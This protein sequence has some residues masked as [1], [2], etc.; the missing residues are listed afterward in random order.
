MIIVNEVKRLKNEIKALW[1]SHNKPDVAK[2]E[3]L[4]FEML[5][6]Y[7][8]I[9]QQQAWP[10]RWENVDALYTF[11]DRISAWVVDDLVMAIWAS[12][13]QGLPNS[14][15]NWD[16]SEKEAGMALMLSRGP[17]CLREMTDLEG[18]NVYSAV[19]VFV[20]PRQELLTIKEGAGCLVVLVEQAKQSDSS[21]ESEVTILCELPKHR[22]GRF[23]PSA[24]NDAYLVLPYTT[25]KGK[26]KKLRLDFSMCYNR[27]PVVRRLHRWQRKLGDLA[28]LPPVFSSDPTLPILL[29]VG[30]IGELWLN[31]VFTMPVAAGGSG[32]GKGRPPISRLTC[33]RQEVIA[34]K[35]LADWMDQDRVVY[36]IPPAPKD[37]T[38]DEPDEPNDPVDD[39]QC[40]HGGK[41]DENATSKKEEDESEDDSDDESKV[42]KDQTAVSRD[43]SLGAS[44]S[45]HGVDASA[46]AGNSGIDLNMGPPLPGLPMPTW[47]LSMD[48]LEQLGDDLY[49]YSGELFWGLEKTSLAMLDRILSG[50][51]RSGSRAREYIYE[52]AA[53]A[54]NFFSRA[55]DMEAKL[56]SSEALKFREVVNGMKESIH[57]LIR[58]TASAE[59]SYENAAAN[60]DNILASVSD[61]VKEFEDSHGEEQ[62]QAYIFRSME[63][64]RGVH[65]SLDGTQFIPLVVSNTT[66]HHAL[67]M[68][69]RVNQSQVPLQIMMLPMRTQ[70]GTMGTGLKFIEYLSKRVLALDVKLGPTTTVS[71]ESGGEGP[72]VQSSTGTGG[73][74]TPKVASTPAS[75]GGPGSS[76]T[77]LSTP[78]PPTAAH[79]HGA[80]RAKTPDM[81]SK[82]KAMFSP[83]ASAA[84]AKFKGMSDDDRSSRKRRGESS[85]REVVSKKTKVDDSKKTKVDDFKKTK[86]DDFKKTNVD[87]LKKPKVDGFKIAIDDDD[88]DSYLSPTP[89]KS[90]PP[91][92][93]VKKK[94][95]KKKVPS[96]DES[97]SSSDDERPAPKKSKIDRA[98]AVAWMN[99][100]RANKWKRDL[101]H[102]N[103]YR[104]QK[105]LY[106][107]DLTGGPNS[108]HHVDLLTQLLGARQLGLN[109]THIDTRLDELAEESSSSKSARRLLKALKEVHAETMGRS[110]VYP[111]YVVK[112][113]LEP[114]SQCVIQKGDSNHWD[115]SAMIG[116]YNLH[117]YEAVGKGNK[118]VDSKMVTKGYCSFC[119]YNAGN[120]GSINNHI[121]V[122]YR[123]VLEC[124]FTNC[125]VIMYDAERMVAH[126]KDKHKLETD[127]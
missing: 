126:S 34:G 26:P 86:V 99:L 80:S 45:G 109:I 93:E 64:I 2:E 85:S 17:S 54:L 97:S 94:K 39:D 67:A 118:K 23:Y 8:H 38:A 21:S 90:E 89:H 24:V 32:L 31:E 88:S 77:P 102:V 46:E 3:L 58:R 84:L 22:H 127:A 116:L 60:F 49:A 124:G 120:N 1:K 105:G 68:S 82:P 5:D 106:A 44:Y 37:D 69:H 81:P 11:T 83:K 100:D 107:K 20:H 115:T 18:E 7:R 43:S 51:K 123:L 108:T 15:A 95:T 112:A 96:S 12:G 76:K 87:D 122:H 59:E 48:V 72:G 33:C 19:V 4:T 113:F 66:I 91:K 98:E 16:S 30:Y 125:N 42:P 53:I 92:K 40:E 52:T 111:E 27:H 25:M 61:E 103:R 71:L 35:T 28:L 101:E 104:Q 57:D 63:R 73:R 55:R 62:H 79:I 6:R 13:R 29:P 36:P 65:G 119:E 78:T 75:S 14:F 70:A 56:E 74:A 41:P 50:F 121:R 117:K 110:G 10:W 114:Q 47:L 9:V